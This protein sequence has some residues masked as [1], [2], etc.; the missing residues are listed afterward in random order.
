[1]PN[2]KVLAILS[3]VV[4]IG[5]AVLSVVTHGN[6]PAILGS[7][8]AGVGMLLWG[9]GQS[10]RTSLILMVIA[11]GSAALFF[12][13]DNFWGLVVSGLIFVWCACGLLPVMDAAWRAK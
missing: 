6:V 11:A 1:M 10:R 5:L 12:H 3:G 4:A 8:G 9:G 2:K 7:M 13:F